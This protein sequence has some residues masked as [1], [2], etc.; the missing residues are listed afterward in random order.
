MVKFATNGPHV[1]P[2][3]EELKAN[4]DKSLTD[5]QNQPPVDP[6]AIPPTTPLDN[7]QTPPAAPTPPTQPPATPPEIKIEEVRAKKAEDLSES[8][9]KSCLSRSSAQVT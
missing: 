2:S 3:K 4:I 7:Q 5:L 9:Q 8:D 1:K 6:P